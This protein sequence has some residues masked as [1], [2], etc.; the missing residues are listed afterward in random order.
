[1]HAVDLV[2]AEA[3]HHAVLDHGLAT[4]AALFGG[5][6]DHHGGPVE[7]P[8]L[9]KVLGRP[10]QHRGV[11]VMAAAMHPARD[12]RGMRQ[13]RRLGHR[14]RVHV[15]PQAHGVA[16]R[17]RLAPDHADDAGAP[18]PGH[19]LVHAE[20][21]QLFLDHRRGHRQV[22]AELGIHVDLAP[23]ARD[24]GHQF[25]QTVLDGHLVPP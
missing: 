14:Q 19:D 10:Q 1:V 24:L 18:D 16:A 2:D 20:L 15:R 8:R 12:G 23:P 7:I 9:G 4:A 3:L 22:I 21:A 11:P 17:V 25:G 13:P 5:L 6:E